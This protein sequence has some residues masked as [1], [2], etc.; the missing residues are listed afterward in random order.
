M[1]AAKPLFVL[2]L[3]CHYVSGLEP[4]EPVGEPFMQNLLTEYEVLSE[5]CDS[6]AQA[7]ARLSEQAVG[8]LET[9]EADDM[10]EIISSAKFNLCAVKDKTGLVREK[11]V[12]LM[13]N[14]IYNKCLVDKQCSA[15][16]PALEVIEEH[17]YSRTVKFELALLSAKDL[18]KLLPANLVWMKSYRATI[19]LISDVSDMFSPFITPTV[20]G[21]LLVGNTPI[22]MPVLIMVLS[23]TFLAFINWKK[24]LALSFLLI[25]VLCFM[26]LPRAIQYQK[27]HQDTMET[28]ASIQ[29]IKITTGMN[30]VKEFQ[31]IA[32]Y[33]DLERMKDA[34]TKAIEVIKATV[35][36]YSNHVRMLKNVGYSDLADRS[37]EA[38]GQFH[39]YITS[40]E[41]LMLK[42]SDF[43][44]YVKE[45]FEIVLDMK[46]VKLMEL[47]RFVRGILNASIKIE[48]MYDDHRMTYLGLIGKLDSLKQDAMKMEQAN[49]ETMASIKNIA[50]WLTM[51]GVVLATGGVGLAFGGVG[52]AGKPQLQLI[53]KGRGKKNHH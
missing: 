32:A 45:T 29:N 41:K 46:S 53:C 36:D 47:K 52:L 10:E 25:L 2:T 42:S 30:D 39:K 50:K 7:E 49:I 9:K 44:A 16:M 4:S 43:F 17:F 1:I 22:Q 18:E 12:R 8:V 3:F 38:Y 33:R 31:T 15:M 51:G 40:L 35:P 11:L 6:L 20:P 24:V 27:L 14:A 37:Q 13:N 5:A 21:V 26:H 48:E 23:L 28:V 19:Q 34:A